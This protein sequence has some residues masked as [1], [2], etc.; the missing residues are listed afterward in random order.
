MDGL[1][2]V[3]WPPRL[4]LVCKTGDTRVLQT[5]A[6]PAES[7]VAYRMGFSNERIITKS[8]EIDPAGPKELVALA[9][10]YQCPL[11]G[12]YYL[13]RAVLRPLEGKMLPKGHLSVCIDGESIVNFPLS[14]FLPDPE[15]IDC[16]KLYPWVETKDL[17]KACA[18]VNDVAMGAHRLGFMLPNATKIEVH[19]S[20]I[21]AQEK[22]T[23]ELGILS[24]YY[25]T[26][27]EE[28]VN[29][30]KEKKA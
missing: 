8:V 24:A 14:Y 6:L 18:L 7:E 25:S 15:P 5:P 19:L 11:W 10:V 27:E 29:P 9:H 2:K 3:L 16:K 21:E 20:L 4:A 17:Y 22:V 12:A 13:A 23:L 26:K 30:Y 28:I 1:A